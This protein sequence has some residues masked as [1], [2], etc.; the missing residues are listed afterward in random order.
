[1]HD[2]LVDACARLLRARYVFP[3][4]AQTAAA[5]LEAA[6]AAGFYDGLDEDAFIERVTA[7]LYSVCADRH[8]ELRRATYAQAT[9]PTREEMS[10][11]WSQ[12]ERQENYGISTVRHL[13]GN[14]GYL[15]LVNISDPNHG[16]GAIAAAM[17]LV[18]MTRALI[19]DLRYNGGGSPDGVQFWCSYFFPD[20][21][22]HLNSVFD[23]QTGVTRQYWT[24]P[25]VP[26]ARYL[27]RPIWLL[28]S[29]DT[30]SGAEEFCYNLQS[31]GRATLVGETTG[32]GA[33]PTEPIAITST[34]QINIPIKRSI[35]PVTG[36]N[37]E[38]TGVKP[39]V[40]T[41]TDDAYETAYWLARSSM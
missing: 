15:N 35:N 10:A 40:P 7:Q 14:I 3:E 13:D 36:T 23:P 30:F 11:I 4:K 33:H 8:L 17:E 21:A 6:L 22:T 27:D 2:E 16:A 29:S 28:T 37:W 31:Q 20:A 34:I 41:H 39:D 26:G 18:S 25:H 12:Q 38:G 19:I 32:G 1:M 9:L 5:L 24:L